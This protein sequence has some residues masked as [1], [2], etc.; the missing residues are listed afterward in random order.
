M[1]GDITGIAIMLIAS[2]MHSY[3]LVGEGKHFLGLLEIWAGTI[4]VLLPHCL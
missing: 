3:C 2:C 1:E 4:R